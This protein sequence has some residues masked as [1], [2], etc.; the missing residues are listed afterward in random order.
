M[1][2][3]GVTVTDHQPSIFTRAHFAM[4]TK[5]KMDYFYI[6]KN[7]RNLRQHPFN[8]MNLSAN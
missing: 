8:Y 4:T 7:E 3:S 1:G 2:I 5:C 6:Q